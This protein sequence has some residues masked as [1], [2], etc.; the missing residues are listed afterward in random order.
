MT[1]NL[2]NISAFDINQ[3]IA[4]PVKNDNNS[5]L[6]AICNAYCYVYITEKMNDM[7]IDRTQFI[8]KLREQIASHIETGK[9]G[10]RGVMEENIEPKN[11]EKLSL[12]LKSSQALGVEIIPLISEI[13]H[14]DIFVLDSQTKEIIF[15]SNKFVESIPY[16]L[17]LMSYSDYL[18]QTVNSNKSAILLFYNFQTKHFDTA[19]YVDHQLRHWSLFKSE[20]EVIKEIKNKVYEFLHQ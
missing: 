11:R 4:L 7:N 18:L 16:T 14:Y 20:H 10:E 2:L 13:I 5:L 19:A 17:D 8:K 12:Y 9:M 15:N 1:S 3:L 6:H